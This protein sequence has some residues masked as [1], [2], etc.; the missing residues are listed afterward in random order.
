MVT[1]VQADHVRVG[2]E[3]IP[4]RNVVWAAG[5]KASPLGAR[6]GVETDRAGRVL[7]HPDLSIP[8]HPEVF[9]IGDLSSLAAPD[10]RPLPGV[11]QVAMQMGVRAA[12]NI[13]ADVRG[14]PRAPFRYRDKGNMATIGRRAAVLESGRLTLTGPL[15]WFAW[16]FIHVLF[17][18][19]F[20]NR[21]AVLVQWAWSYLTWQRGARLI[22]GTVGADLA[23][24]GR[25]LGAPDVEPAG[26]AT[27]AR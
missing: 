23:P 1:D 11:A 12:R 20:R 3:V 10:G 18:I 15:A 5:V 26:A 16:L 8:G 25:P 22:P 19:G 7:I 14:V 6:L 9:V 13:V 21:L 24:P 27:D 2:E 4:A 17:L